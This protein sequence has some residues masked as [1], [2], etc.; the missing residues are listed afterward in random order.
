MDIRRN[1]ASFASWTDGLL[2]EITSSHSSPPRLLEETRIFCVTKSR[3][4]R[5]YAGRIFAQPRGKDR[6]WSLVPLGSR[7]S[8][9]TIIEHHYITIEH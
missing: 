1:A 2:A 8:L 3:R 5:K 4:F 9:V 6:Q 7:Y